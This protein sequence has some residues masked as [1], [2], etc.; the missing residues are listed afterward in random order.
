MLLGA[1]LLTGGF[2]GALPDPAHAQ[3][4]DDPADSSYEAARLSWQALSD[5]LASTSGV[6][7]VVYVHAPW[8]GPCR[9]LER[10]V[11]PEVRPLLQRFTRAHLNFDDTERS[12]RLGTV[13]Q[14]PFD[15]ARHFGIDATPGLIF[16]DANGAVIT[17]TTGAMKAE[18]LKYLLAFI[19]TGAHRH[20]DF[21]TY[22]ETVSAAGSPTADSPN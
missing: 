21:E 14:S 8:C 9:K 6:P 19:A 22:L 15:W 7:T 2:A 13:S 4:A 5:A 3:P 18:S 12:L 10:D 1:F 16:L 20:T 11:F 17:T